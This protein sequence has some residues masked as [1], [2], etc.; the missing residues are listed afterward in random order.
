LWVIGIGKNWGPPDPKVAATLI[1]GGNYDYVTRTV[2]WEKLVE[3]ELPKSLYL[4]SKPPFFGEHV[5]PWVDPTGPT[6]LHT[7]PARARF[8]AGTPFVQLGGA[9]P[10]R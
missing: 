5:W 8:D 10:S 4:T 7:L 6:K 3:Q 9:A 1:R 2:H